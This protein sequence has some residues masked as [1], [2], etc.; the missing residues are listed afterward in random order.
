VKVK[1]VGVGRNV[2]SRYT[3]S[4]DAYQQYMLAGKGTPVSKSQQSA[5]P[6]PL[7]SPRSNQK[8]RYQVLW[9]SILN[10]IENEWIFCDVELE[11]VLNSMLNIRSRLPLE[12][13]LMKNSVKEADEEWMQYGPRAIQI[14]VHYSSGYLSRDDVASAYHYDLLQHERLMAICRKFMKKLS[15]ANGALL[16]HVDSLMKHALS[17]EADED[18]AVIL[19]NAIEC[20]KM[21]SRELF[22]KQSSVARVLDGDMYDLKELAKCVDLWGFSNKESF[23]DITFLKKHGI[24]I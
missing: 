8:R 12:R 21:L 17:F 13:S 23:V 11:R 22:R 10:C 16:R 20:Q 18:C 14:G 6:S 1:F 4:M 24:A 7:R 15:D 9:K 5:T 19:T 2:I 3:H